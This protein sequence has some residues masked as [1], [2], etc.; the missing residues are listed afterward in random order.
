MNP[1]VFKVLKIVVGAASLALPVA[2]GYFEHQEMKKLIAKE[3]AEALKNQT[4]ES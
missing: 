4:R 3:V 2:S 1:T